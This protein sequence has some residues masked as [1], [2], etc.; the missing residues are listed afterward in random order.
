[1]R[2]ITSKR[3]LT[4]VLRVIQH[5][6]ENL[7]VELD[8]DE[9]SAVS[10]LSPQH[11]LR[12]FAL[13]TGEKLGSYIRK[14]S[15]TR[16]AQKLIES[17]EII[18]NIAF[19]SGYESQEAFSRAFKKQFKVTP[20]QYRLKQ[21]HTNLYEKESLSEKNIRALVSEEIISE[22]IKNIRSVK[23]FN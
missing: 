8:V 18:I 5:I 11:F 7:S 23:K 13:C 10:K 14:R 17:R 16:A 6:E 4:A 20:R 21:E 15:L 22:P 12:V 1:M 9:L 2:K 19:D 3:Y